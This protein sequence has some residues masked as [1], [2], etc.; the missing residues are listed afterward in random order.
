MGTQSRLNLQIDVSIADKFCTATND[1]LSNA[2]A[3]FE[4]MDILIKPLIVFVKCWS[5]R[6]KIN[7]AYRRYLNSYGYTLLVISFLQSNDCRDLTLGHLAYAFFEFYAVDFD[8][9]MHAISVYL[10]SCCGVQG[11][12][13]QNRGRCKKKKFVKKRFYEEKNGFAVIEIIDPIN[14]QNNVAQSVGLAQWK[15]IKQEFVN[16]HNLIKKYKDQRMSD[17][18]DIFKLTS[19]FNLLLQRNGDIVTDNDKEDIIHLDQNLY[20]YDYKAADTME[21]MEKYGKDFLNCIDGNVYHRNPFKKTCKDSSSSEAI[22]KKY[23]MMR[24]KTTIPMR[25]FEHRYGNPFKRREIIR[26]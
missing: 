14:L 6:K 11:H 12:R 7:N 17:S 3:Y 19:I 23:G 4:S 26:I 21:S 10:V 9:K 18:D 13:G 24:K 2:I 15:H 22:A 1:F 20:V 16:A 5:K 25:P 8:A